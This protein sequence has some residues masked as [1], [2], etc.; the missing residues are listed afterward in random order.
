[1]ETFRLNREETRQKVESTNDSYILF[2][3]PGVGK[4]TI[5]R[6]PRMVS[7]TTLSLEYQAE[8][9]DAV[10]AAINNQISYQAMTVV[11]DDIGIEDNVKHFGSQLDPIV[12][13][14]QRIYDVNQTAE[15]KIRLLLTTNLNKDE[16]VERYGIRIVDRLYEM[17]HR[18]HLDDTNLR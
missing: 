16:L 15:Q 11:I 12:Y 10:R 1:M 13:A 5:V 7:A 6:K 4:T 3:A 8:G 2:G 18:I 17:C 14:I 9:L